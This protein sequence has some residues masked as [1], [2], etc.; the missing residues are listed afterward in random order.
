MLNITH[1]DISQI[2]TQQNYATS[3]VASKNAESNT[4]SQSALSPERYSSSST[5]V[6]ISD[7][8]KDK[9]AQEQSDIG[10]DLAEKMLSKESEKTPEDSVSDIERLDKIIEDIQE[11]IK[12]IQQQIRALNGEKTEQARAQRKALDAQLSSLNATLLGLMGKK[13][14]A[15]EPA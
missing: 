3:V 10:K 11:Q 15:I 5:V 7:E 6:N 4:L 13:L 2:A 9:L 1:Y 12:E 8:A 14:D